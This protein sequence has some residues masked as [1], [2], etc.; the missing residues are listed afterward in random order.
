MNAL[1]PLDEPLDDELLAALG[2]ARLTRDEEAR[3]LEA[4]RASPA[5]QAAFRDL[6]PG[7]YATLFGQNVV[8]LPL[9]SPA[10]PPSAR[11]TEPPAREAGLGVTPPMRADWRL[12]AFGLVASF[13]VLVALIVPPAAPRFSQVAYDTMRVRGPGAGPVEPV[14][15]MVDLGESTAW[16]AFRGRRPWGAVIVAGADGRP[17][18]LATSTRPAECTRTPSTLACL[19]RTGYREVAV[20]VATGPADAPLDALVGGNPDWA[21]FR[22]AL[23]AAASHE[24]WRLHFPLDPAAD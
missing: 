22:A 7:R 4:L 3:A 12:L 6:F 15:L 9:P 2:E 17:V 21:T 24:P 20:L 13:A 19:D 8:P 18:V 1:R 11:P 14:A 5:L 10:Q 16:D 23:Q